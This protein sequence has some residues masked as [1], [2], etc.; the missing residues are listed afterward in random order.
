[1]KLFLQLILFLLVYEGLSQS[2]IG[3]LSVVE[4]GNNQIICTDEDFSFNV[5]GSTIMPSNLNLPGVNYNPGVGLALFSQM[6]SYTNNEL[7]TDPNLLGIVLTQPDAVFLSPFVFDYN[8]ILAL[9][10]PPLNTLS[11]PTTLYFQATTLYDYVTPLPYANVIGSPI[12]PI[13]YH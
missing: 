3:L 11:S 5:L 8:D 6:P 10:P 13:L 4:D 7:L 12:N 9:I 1:M 2:S